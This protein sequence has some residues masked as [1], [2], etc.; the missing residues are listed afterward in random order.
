MKDTERCNSGDGETI[1]KAGSCNG[2]PLVALR[3]CLRHPEMY[4]QPLPGRWIL[5]FALEVFVFIFRGRLF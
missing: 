5:L 3:P 4:Q 2:Q 1:E